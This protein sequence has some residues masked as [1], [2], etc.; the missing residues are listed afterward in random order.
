MKPV[1]VALVIGVMVFWGLNFVYGKWAVVELPPIFAIACRFGLLALML[2]PFVR[3]PR[4]HLRGIFMLSLTLGC[5]HFSLFFTG[6]SMLGPGLASIVAQSQVAFAT[7]IGAALYHDYP[8]WRRWLGMLLAFLGIWVAWGEPDVQGS[9]L[10]I[11]L[12]LAGSF[13]WAIANFQIKALSRVESFALNG[14]MALFAVPLL[15]AVSFSLESGHV[16]AIRAASGYA[17]FGIAYM[18][19]VISLCTYWVWYRLLRRY[20]V[21][22][23]VPYTLLVPVFGVL[24]GVLLAG[25]PLGWRTIAGCALT[26]VGVAIITLRRPGQADP[27]ARSKSA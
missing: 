14:Y 16:E 5:V 15:L 10:G 18:A 21:N 25:D 24:S 8:G 13:V 26:V 7:I 17:W 1:D 3:V 27:E 23:V 12:C 20:E 4:D 11:A 19:A 2:V 9:P 6:L 22:L